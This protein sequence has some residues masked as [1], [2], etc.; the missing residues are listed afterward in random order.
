MSPHSTQ[1]GNAVSDGTMFDA[2]LNPASLNLPERPRVFE[3]R[4]E[5]CADSAEEDA[6]K[7]WVILDDSQPDSEIEKNAAMASIKPIHDAIWRALKSAQVERWP[8]ISF[9]L[10]SEQE[11]LD[12]GTYYDDDGH[13]HA[14]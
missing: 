11:Q 12:A 9:R 1:H 14:A 3:I 10:K 8:Y 2:L 5:L 13:E 4:H 7:I 6:V